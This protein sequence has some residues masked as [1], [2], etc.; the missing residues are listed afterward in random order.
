MKAYLITHIVLSTLALTATLV[1]FFAGK[2]GAP[3]KDVASSLFNIAW[4]A[5]A[6]YLLVGLR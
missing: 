3:R 5:W 2:S 1:P 6:V 4:I